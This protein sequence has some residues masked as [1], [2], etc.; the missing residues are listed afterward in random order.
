MPAI[1]RGEPRGCLPLR[2]TWPQGLT[3]FREDSDTASWMPPSATAKQLVL[4]A[5]RRFRA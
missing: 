2:A 3:S 4:A 1:G 5:T